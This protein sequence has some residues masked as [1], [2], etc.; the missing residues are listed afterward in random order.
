MRRLKPYFQLVR[1]PNV[2][3]AAAD[4]LSGWLLVGGALVDVGGWLP[5]VLAS[6]AIY[7]S[8]I[9]LN[10]VFDLELDRVE[11]PGR[12]L[13]SGRVS[14]RFAVVLAVVLLAF[15]LASASV[16][17]TRPA[18]VASALIAGVV[19]YDAGIRRTVL[20]PELMGACRG[21]NVLL[22][23]SLAPGL[24]G[25]TAW[26]VAGGMAV[27]IVGVTW[28]SRFETAVGRRAAPAAGMALQAIGLSALVWAASSAAML[29]QPG[30]APSRADRV[31]MLAIGL[32]ILAIA[33]ARILRASGRAVADP[34]PQT[35]QL[36]VKTGILSLIW[37]HVGVV[38]GS[39]GPVE[40]I[41]VALLWIPSA[42]AA[43]WIYST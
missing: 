29:P 24:G 17:G 4:S 38:A 31:F 3:T 16:V 20:G 25:P 42:L 37:L 7:A 1:L 2:F 12:P 21:L 23:M 33:S 28:I 32:A 15:G 19:A 14:R 40:A 6:M 36:A 18:V 5:L 41:A 9:A 10:D 26:A 8:G 27:F 30:P 34:R 35:L 22:G 13:P 11:R 39:R 43:R